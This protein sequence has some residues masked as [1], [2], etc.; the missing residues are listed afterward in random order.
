MNAQSISDSLLMKP[1]CVP[2]YQMCHAF[3]K[4]INHKPC[5]ITEDLEACCRVLWTPRSAPDWGP[6]RLQLAGEPL[7]PPTVSSHDPVL[8]AK[9]RVSLPHDP[10]APQPLVNVDG[11]GASS[12]VMETCALCG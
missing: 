7:R 12:G 3:W 11:Q 5:S 4:R 6:L 1:V 10:R 9:T 2:Q 8:Q